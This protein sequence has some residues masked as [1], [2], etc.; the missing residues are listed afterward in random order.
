M[1]LRDAGA[2]DGPD[3]ARGMVRWMNAIGASGLW[4]T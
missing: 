3:L 2:H 1:Q 4:V